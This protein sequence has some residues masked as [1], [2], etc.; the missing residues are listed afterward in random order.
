MLAY[1]VSTKKYSRFNNKYTRPQKINYLG[2]LRERHLK[3]TDT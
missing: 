2:R 1:P 3:L